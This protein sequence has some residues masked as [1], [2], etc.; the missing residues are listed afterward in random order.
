MNQDQNI[1]FRFW[2]LDC[3]RYEVRRADA[4]MACRFCGYF[5]ADRM[6]LD[7]ATR[8]LAEHL[9]GCAR[10][11]WPTLPGDV[12]A[13]HIECH[14]R[15]R[16]LSGGDVLPT[17]DDGDCALILGVTTCAFGI[18]DRVE[19]PPLGTDPLKSC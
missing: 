3:G 8:L 11:G 13:H 2:T 12:P 7:T 10:F 1:R 14:P 17:L 5:I 15:Y 4:I 16:K 19:I 18:F 9:N 6:S